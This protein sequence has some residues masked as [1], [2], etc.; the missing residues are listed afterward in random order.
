[1]KI[2][3][4][5]GFAIIGLTVLIRMVFQP[6]YKQQMEMSKKM[7][8][9]KPK[10][11]SLAQKYKNDQKTLQQEQMKLYQ[12][13]GINPAAGCLI[14]IIQLPIFFAL[15]NTLSVFLMNGQ[16]AKAISQINNVLYT[17]FLKIGTIDPWF[18]GFNLALS[19]KAGGQWFYLLIPLL[20]GVLQYFQAV[21]MTPIQPAT[22]VNKDEK[23]KKDDGSDFQKAM[24]TQMKYMFP[25]M[26]GWFSYTLPVGLS[27]YWNIFSLFSIIQGRKLKVKN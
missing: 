23:N 5:F 17:P 7:Q 24:T 14:M 4:A 9:M 3:G 6:F 12:Q 20:T 26:I 22:P 8:E 19:P 18:F 1:M 10:L 25:V 16:A 2:P 27:L 13:A 21:S 11:D 15:Y